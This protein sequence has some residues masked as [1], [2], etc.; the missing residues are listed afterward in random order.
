MN[1][2]KQSELK[3]KFF[4]TAVK[5]KEYLLNSRVKYFDGTLASLSG[6]QETELNKRSIVILSSQHYYV[7]TKAYPIET[8]KELLQVLAL[9]ECEFPQCDR[10]IFNIRNIEDGKATVDFW[11]FSSSLSD[12]IGK[13][14]LLIPASFIQAQSDLWQKKV[15][16]VSNSLFYQVGNRISR[17]TQKKP[18]LAFSM[19]G[20]ESDTE[21]EKLSKTEY[22]SLLAGELPKLSALSYK[23]LAQQYKGIPEVN[24]RRAGFFSSL[25]VILT[26]VGLFLFSQYQL[27]TKQAELE[28]LS[29][30]LNEAFELKKQSEKIEEGYQ[31]L[32][33]TLPKEEVSSAPYWKVMADMYALK[34]QYRIRVRFHRFQN[35]KFMASIVTNNATEILKHFHSDPRVKVV[36]RGNT[37]KGRDGEIITI[38]LTMLSAE[39][40]NQ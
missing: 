11:E 33:D 7:R 26:F 10:L 29:T 18:M 25:G 15:L 37:A 32:I 19:L 21:V 5:L 4:H 22:F 38:E 14:H 16:S 36:Q 27:D 34:G 13:K 12:A 17:T 20:V 1:I 39:I 31:E 3:N 9:E 6:S 30:T 24:L 40:E 2:N 35:G 23:Q 28:S 8:K